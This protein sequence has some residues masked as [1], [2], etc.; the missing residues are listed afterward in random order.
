MIFR[1]GFTVANQNNNEELIRSI[2][3]RII[4]AL[5][6]DYFSNTDRPYEFK[7]GIKHSVKVID[8]WLKNQGIERG[9]L[10]GVKEELPTPLY[11]H[12]YF[13]RKTVD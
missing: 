13:L 8:E 2:A 9:I 3:N 12:S 6:E 5:I 4:E 11:E 1:R 7:K 10:N